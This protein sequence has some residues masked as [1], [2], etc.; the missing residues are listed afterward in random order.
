MRNANDFVRRSV[1]R[2]KAFCWRELCFTIVVLLLAIPR[3]HGQHFPATVTTQ[4]L[5]PYSVYLSDYFS[6]GSDKLVATVIFNDYNEPSRDVRLRLRIESSTVRIQSRADFIPSVP[7]N[8]TPGVPVRLTGG[9]LSEYFDYNNLQFSGITQAVFQQ[10]ARLPEGMYSFCLEVVDYQSGKVLSPPS[11]ATAWLLL[12]DPPKIINPWCGNYIEPTE[13]QLINFQWQQSNGPAPNAGLPPQYKL[14][15]HEVIEPTT[16]PRSA[17]VNGKTVQIFESEPTDQLSYLYDLSAPSLEAGKGYVFQVQA[18]DPDGRDLYKNQ[19][20]SEFCWFYYGYPTGGHISITR[21]AHETAFGKRDQVSFKWSAPDKRILGQPFS[22]Y[23]KIVKLDKNQDPETAI[24]ENPA[25]FERTTAPL[26]KT[27]G[28]S[29]RLKQAL[30][31]MTDYAWQVTAVSGTQEVASSDV[32]TFKGPGIIEDFY[33]GRHLVKVLSTENADLKNLSGIGQLK[34]SETDTLTLPF[35]NLD[36]EPVGSMFHRLN[37][38]QITYEYE[39]PDTISLAPYDRVSENGPA[40]FYTQQL[41]LNEEELMVQGFA[42]W[43]LPHPTTSDE[44][45]RIRSK[46]FWANFDKYMPSGNGPI[47][48]ELAVEL[49][50][51]YRFDLVLS[52]QTQMLVLLDRYEIVF[53]G[54]IRLPESVRGRNGQRVSLPFSRTQQL[55]FFQQDN[56]VTANPILPVRKSALAVYPKKITVDLSEDKSP[57]KLAGNPTWKGVYID[58]FGVRSEKAMDP[59]NQLLLNEEATYDFKVADHKVKNWIS[60]AG[61][62]LS[63]AKKYSG[64]SEAFFNSFPSRLTEFALNI[65]D[66]VVSD[67]YMK[68]TLLIPFI[69]TTQPFGYTI[70]ISSYGFREGVVDNLKGTS[71]TFNKNQGHQEVVITVQRYKFVNRERIEMALDLHWP[72]FD[73]DLTSVHGFSVWGNHAIGFGQPNGALSLTN[74]VNVTIDNYP[75]TISG[76]G[77]GSSGGHY[78]F[79]ITGNINVGDDVSGA[80]GPPTTN[81]YSIAANPY[82]SKESS[83]G[84]DY[85]EA[86]Q[87]TAS[88]RPPPSI[89]QQAIAQR[90]SEYIEEANA[91]KDDLTRGNT[92]TYSN[93][94]IAPVPASEMDPGTAEL[95]QLINDFN[96]RQRAYFDSLLSAMS[97]PVTYLINAEADRLNEKIVET[98]DEK[99]DSVNAKIATK[100]ATI[101]D[102]LRDRALTT[103]S[104]DNDAVYEQIMNASERIK[105]VTTEEVTASVSLSV[106]KNVTLGLTRYIKNELA[107]SAAT[108]IKDEMV[109][110]GFDVK[111]GQ[112]QA[113]VKGNV[114]EKLGG[115]AQTILDNNVDPGRIASSVSKLGDDAFNGIDTKVILDQLIGEA[116]AIVAVAAAEA[117]AGDALDDLSQHVGVKIPMDFNNLGKKIRTGDIKGLLAFD[118]ISVSVRTKFVDLQG[119]IH[120]SPNDPIFGTVWRGDIDFQVK[121]PKKFSLDGIYI[122]GRKDNNSYW[123]CQI[124]P[125]DGKA[126]T[127]GDISRGVK[128]LD[129]PVNMGL[130]SMEAAAGRVY[131]GMRDDGKRILPDP[132]MAYGA[133]LNFVF[134]DAKKRGQT[135]R[136]GLAAGIEMRD[137]GDYLVGFNGD[138]QAGSKAPKVLLPDPNASVLGTAFIKYNSAEEHFIGRADAVVNSDALCAEGSVL[139]D[140]K[141]GAW[142]VAL[143]SRDNRLVFVPG[144]V[145]WSPTGWLD[146][147]QSTLSLG[148]GLQYSFEA[149][150]SLKVAGVSF[151]VGVDAGVAA[152]LQA[153][154]QYD[155]TLILMEAGIWVDIWGRV[156][157]D[158]SLLKKTGSINLVD[159]YC[160]GDLLV[161]FQPKPTTLSGNVSG[162]VRVIGIGVDF[163]AGFETTLK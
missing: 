79:G 127:G 84:F 105:T 70:P 103:V 157:V 2:K 59:T 47:E 134:F 161:K 16:D 60:T 153:K 31:P 40:S 97:D 96:Q 129:S 122:N 135:L 142:R 37:K 138:L 7:I 141:P 26:Q 94:E 68:G 114:G 17:V 11:C 123:F 42:E 83:P 159:I 82:A 145:G 52:E 151:G 140:V 152:G 143:G 116:T 27:Y 156:Y 113:T 61:L 162:Y 20:F 32:Y 54:H 21:P 133:Y 100:V 64:D 104:S 72:S 5:P 155:P 150:Q 24:I 115:L 130:V 76:I 12:S 107:A 57:A 51:P 19:G 39:R 102:K 38:G 92:R 110:V 28:F 80:E 101:V 91:E 49:L 147:N 43:Q 69:S 18:I 108:Y 58:D 53:D 6:P 118:P 117:L 23:F 29:F 128:P 90:S 63:V 125:S 10:N 30:D 25:W 62:T 106:Q 4:V 67:S 144:C 111:E 3:V 148:L 45:V 22:Y 15:V 160:Q 89:D 77:A 14:Y 33:A 99:T 9:D 132:N 44:P 13:P 146:I 56:L 124:S 34:V 8:I 46:S 95:Y 75:V 98:I 93:I 87:Q 41:K 86:R 112:A 136:L 50:D 120:H 71:F 139:V 35:H 65:K 78:S 88:T 81:V 126:P 36:I 1:N 74:Q 48:S 119:L 137:N 85:K 121:V 109:S 149:Y 154:V 55:F 73:A 66:N 158:Y 131:R 163:D